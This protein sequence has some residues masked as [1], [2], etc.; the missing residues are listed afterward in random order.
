MNTWLRIL[1]C[2]VVVSYASMW[3]AASAQ[4]DKEKKAAESTHTGRWRLAVT[5]AN[6]GGTGGSLRLTQR[7]KA[8]TWAPKERSWPLGDRKLRHWGSLRS[9]KNLRQQP[10]VASQRRPAGPSG[11]GS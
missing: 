7:A 8:P 6:G 4:T 1:L 3:S 10:V 11:V 2:L 9:L 5:F